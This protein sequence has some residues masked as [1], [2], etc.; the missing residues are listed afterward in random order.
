[1]YSSLFLCFCICGSILL[2]SISPPP[3][4]FSSCLWV[5]SLSLLSS[6]NSLPVILPPLLVCESQTSSLSSTTSFF[7]R[8]SGVISSETALCLPQKASQSLDVSECVLWF[9]TQISRS[10]DTPPTSMA[11]VYFRGHPALVGIMYHFWHISI[12]L[13]SAFLSHTSSKEFR[14]H[15]SGCPF[16]LL[17]SHKPCEIDCVSGSR[18]PSKLYVWQGIWNLCFQNLRH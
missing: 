1:M 11:S 13:S 4:S 17:F 8:L 14:D 18:S 6:L 5:L 7:H 12:C 9:F 2:L 15:M 10:T 16:S 3:C